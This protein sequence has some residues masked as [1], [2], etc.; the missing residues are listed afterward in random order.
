[1]SATG[2][3]VRYHSAGASRTTYTYADNRTP[4]QLLATM[5]GA[6]VNDAGATSG[7]TT[8]TTYRAN[9]YFNGAGLCKSPSNEV[10]IVVNPATEL[11]LSTN[12]IENVC[13]G[14]DSPIITITEGAEAY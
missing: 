13:Q 10:E 7:G 9:T 6:V 12:S 2:G 11:V 4:A 14:N 5:T 8:T 1:S 3:N